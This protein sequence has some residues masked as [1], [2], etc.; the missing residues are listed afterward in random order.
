MSEKPKEDIAVRARNMGVGMIRRHIFLC[1]EQTKPKSCTH[2][3]FPSSW[4]QDLGL[5][6]SQQK[7][8]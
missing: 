3:A 4:V 5:V 1:C 2:E 7:K 6:C 8:M